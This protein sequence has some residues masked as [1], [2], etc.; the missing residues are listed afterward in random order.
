[1]IITDD[2]DVS[3]SPAP[4]T[5][6]SLFHGSLLPFPLALAPLIVMMVMFTVAGHQA[7]GLLSFPIE[8]NGRNALL[9]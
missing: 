7:L 3:S 4:T 2:D 9:S 8:S 5:I 6:S 1:M